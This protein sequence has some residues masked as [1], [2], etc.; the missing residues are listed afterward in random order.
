MARRIP[1][2]HQ[3]GNR[4]PFLQC[5]SSVQAVDSRKNRRKWPL[6]VGF[7]TDFALSPLVRTS[8]RRRRLRTP[9]PRLGYEQISIQTRPDLDALDLPPK[10]LPTRLVS[11]QGNRAGI[12]RLGSPPG[13]APVAIGALALSRPREVLPCFQAPGGRA[14][15]TAESGKVRRAGVVN[16]AD[17]PGIAPWS[18]TGIPP[19]LLRRPANCQTHLGRAQLAAWNGILP[20]WQEQ[21]RRWRGGV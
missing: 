19:A 5:S 18:G 15:S 2:T 8:L 12:L 14:A 11:H 10:G 13:I 21:S 7:G 16:P 20:R 6:S 17:C 3:N 4:F 1:L 9:W